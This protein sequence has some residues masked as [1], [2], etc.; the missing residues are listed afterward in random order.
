MIQKT[1]KFSISILL[2]VLNIYNASAQSQP[3][4]IKMQEGSTRQI[5]I[6][7]SVEAI[8]IGDKQICQAQLIDQ[9]TLVLIAGVPGKTNIIASNSNTTKE[10]TIIVQAVFSIKNLKTIFRGIEGLK[11]KTVGQQVILEG[12]VFKQSDM[13]KIYTIVE[14]SP[15]ILNW[16][17][18][19]KRYFDIVGNSIMNEM[20]KFGVIGPKVR[21][22][23]NSFVIDGKIIDQNDFTRI[24][25]NLKQMFK[26]NII[27]NLSIYQTADIPITM[28][29]FIMEIEKDALKNMGIEWNPID[30]V[31]AEG[32]Y[33]TETNKM[34]LLKSMIS[35]T[36]SNLLPKIKKNVEKNKGRALLEKNITTVAGEQAECASVTKIPIKAVNDEGED[37]EK[38]YDIGVRI[39]FSP[40]IDQ[41]RNIRGRIS[42][43][44][45][46]IS[47]YGS[48]GTPV[49]DS[50]N[51]DT[52][53]N[54]KSGKSIVLAGFSGQ[55]EIK[56][57]KNNPIALLQMD[58]SKQANIKNSEVV[59]FVT[60]QIG[61]INGI[62]SRI[63]NKFKETE[64]QNLKAAGV[65]IK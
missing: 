60:P 16:V 29:V 34:P 47:G 49:I 35:G 42:I 38:L 48:Q 12:C 20:K 5:K 25:N 17:T 27:N 40:T 32:S 9:Q 65:H 4:I 57:L 10:I 6:P 62:K 22:V 46:S 1:I 41:N 3:D 14:K 24:D 28:N 59:I 2:I 33:E 18:L 56:S 61:K 51:L 52:F 13:D 21:V 55:R 64:R 53:F 37:S 30:G 39:K 23:N 11:I 44:S 45:S 36:I 31:S 43:E 54:V 7:F 26:Q 19:C 63:S 58:K 8:A 15:N 50:T